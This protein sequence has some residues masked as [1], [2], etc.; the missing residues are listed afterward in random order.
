MV[1]RFAFYL[2]YRSDLRNFISSSFNKSNDR[3]RFNKKFGYDINFSKR[4]NLRKGGYSKFVVE[5]KLK[6]IR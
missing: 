3:C 1:K 2:Y 6:L 5:S 4:V